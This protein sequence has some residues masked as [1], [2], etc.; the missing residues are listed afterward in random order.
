MVSLYGTQPANETGSS[1]QARRPEYLVTCPEYSVTCPAAPLRWGDVTV[2]DHVQV[3][4][5][6]SQKYKVLTSRESGGKVF[7]LRLGSSD[8]KQWLLQEENHQQDVG[9]EDDYRK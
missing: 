3:L 5:C 2:K 6:S 8:P 7:S 9:R 4:L 1:G